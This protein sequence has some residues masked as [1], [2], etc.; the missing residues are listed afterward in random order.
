MQYVGNRANIL[1]E[2]AASTYF[3]QKHIVNFSQLLPDANQLIL[4][5]YEDAQEKLHIAELRALG[6]VH[7][8]I[9]E[10]LWQAVK[11]ADNILSLNSTLHQLHITLF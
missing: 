11:T 4:A 7:K 3:H 9:T 8:V 6:L 10:P 1:F 2:G 5:V